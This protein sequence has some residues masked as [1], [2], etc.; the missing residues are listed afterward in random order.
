[1]KPIYID[2]GDNADWIKRKPPVVAAGQ[3]LDFTEELL[4][5]RCECGAEST[6]SE[7]ARHRKATG[8]S[9]AT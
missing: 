3:S 4:K 1:M 8:H 2:D 6:G 5:L 7:M 9:L